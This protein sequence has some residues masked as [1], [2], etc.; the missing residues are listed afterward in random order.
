MNVKMNHGHSESGANCLGVWG[1]GKRPQISFALSR[2]CEVSGKFLEDLPRAARSQARACPGLLSAAPS[3]LNL[4]ARSSP[5]TTL[6][7]TPALSPR[8]GRIMLRWFEAANGDSCANDSPLTAS[9]VLRRGKPL[10]S[11]AGRGGAVLRWP[12]RRTFERVRDFNTRIAFQL[13]Q[14]TANSGI[15]RLFL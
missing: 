9:A 4:E 12:I 13:H 5:G 3:G 15:W 6:A 2:G 14:L 7:L 8:R 11:P 1:K 10:T